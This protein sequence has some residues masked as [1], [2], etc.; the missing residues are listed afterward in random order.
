MDVGGAGSSTVTVNSIDEFH[1]LVKFA[2]GNVPTGMAALVNPGEVK[3]PA[4][5][6]ASARLNVTAG[7]AL[8]AGTYSLTVRGAAGRPSRDTTVTVK[9]QA[10]TSSVTQVIGGLQALG[11]IDNSGISNALTSRRS[12]QKARCGK[13]EAVWRMR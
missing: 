12:W 4:D 8:A 13:S 2:V 9:V 10:K 6:S 5:G 3:P 1:S 11:C 7:P